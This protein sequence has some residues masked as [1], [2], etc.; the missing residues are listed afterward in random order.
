MNTP[1]LH[2]LA[3]RIEDL[4]QQKQQDLLVR[5]QLRARLT[6]AEQRI[7]EL[8]HT[9]TKILQ[10][11][12]WKSLSGIGG[13]AL[14]FQEAGR[15]F[16][17]RARVAHARIKGGTDPVH[18]YV[19]SP[20]RSA[21]ALSGKVAV[22]GWA[23][24]TSG[25]RAVTIQV[26]EGP[27]IS[28]RLGFPR[29]DIGRLH[30][31]AQGSKN[32][33]F[34][35]SID[36][37]GL[38]EGQHSIRVIA[39][40]RVNGINEVV[41]PFLVRHKDLPR[42]EAETKRVLATL[43]RRP[44]ISI[45]TP[46]YNTPEIWL[47][48]VIESV[49]AQ[50]YPDWELC[51]VDDRSPSP[52]VRPLLEKW[53]AKDSRIKVA[54]RPTNG[55]IA[56]ATNSALELA[57]GEYIA[58]VDHDDEIAPDALLEVAIAYNE[59]PETDMFYSDEDKIDEDGVVSNPFYKPDWSPE[60]F[61]TC[62]Y[63]CHLG[64]YRTSL[65]RELGGF[66]PEVNGAQDY[67]LALRIVAKSNAIHHIP[68]VL[69]HW[70]TLDT[71]T[72]SDAGAK[73][74]AYPAAQRALT[75]YLDVTGREGLVL[76][77]PREGYHRVQFQIKA[78]PRVSVVI[79]SAGR[80]VDYEGRARIDL[81]KMCVDSILSKS[82]WPN[83]EIVV[84]HNCD[85]RPDLEK[86]LSSRVHLVAYAENPF[87]LAQKINMTAAAAS[88]EH[89]IILND[90]IEVITRDWIENMLRYSQQPEVGAVGAKLLFPNGR[91]QHAGVVLLNGAPGHPYYDHPGHDPGYFVSAQVARNYLAVTGACMMTRAD[92]W[93]IVGGFSEDFPLNYNDVDYCLKVRDLGLRTVYVPEAELYHYES[94]SREA[95]KGVKPGELEH[96]KAKW[97]DRYFADPYYNPNLP[98]DYP[99]Y[100]PD[101]S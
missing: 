1:D 81:L 91:I 17:S 55:H 16:Q 8:E 71:S 66:R 4:E 100:E 7:R 87:N 48:R 70:R 75:N 35:A 40:S 2:Q 12:I 28:A 19:D 64:V 72:A 13:L 33:G 51:L 82:T 61:L 65:V 20:R 34:R 90:D 101:L 3:A 36:C 42:S 49:L 96:F 89:L 27:S 31:E 68:K 26:D 39:V 47:N 67:D 5:E 41:E 43:G 76:P 69:Y 79:P 50:S 10:S 52:H 63:T 30:P 25:I 22:K 15:S 74:Y 21:G 9:T 23:V 54:Y 86:W 95:A 45:L 38:S 37:T 60:Y 62:M 92:V 53:A 88:G 85:L 94:V 93:N 14:R 78:K 73:D 77:G 24:A 46:V 44:I 32:A 84:S 29:P 58:L 59:H 80:I 83:I 18:L 97:L 56:K 11:R 99:Y 98:S 57:T 6:Q